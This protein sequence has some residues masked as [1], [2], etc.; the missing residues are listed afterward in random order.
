MSA[1]YQAVQSIHSAIDF[2]F[3]FPFLSYR[4]RNRSNYLACLSVKDESELISLIQKLEKDGIRHSIFR[5]PDIENQI[6]AIAVEPS[7]KSQKICSGLPLALKEYSSNGINKNQFKK[8]N[9]C[10][11]I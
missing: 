7:E 2:I 5:E 4:W 10:E 6:T 8:Q 3:K 1:G 9:L 11:K